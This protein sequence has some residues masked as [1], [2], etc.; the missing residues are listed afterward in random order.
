MSSWYAGHG[1][2]IRELIFFFVCLSSFKGE[3]RACQGLQRKNIFIQPFPSWTME[4][5]SF[6][7]KMQSEPPFHSCKG[8]VGSPPVHICRNYIIYRDLTSR[9][10]HQIMSGI[11]LARDETRLRIEILYRENTPHAAKVHFGRPSWPTPPIQI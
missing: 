6:A 8:N 1:R 2:M 11:R 5:L 10:I 9:L 3:A 7:R 4:L